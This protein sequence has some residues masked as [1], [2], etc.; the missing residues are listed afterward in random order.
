MDFGLLCGMV[1]LLSWLLCGVLP[2]ISNSNV[3]CTFSTL[4]LASVCGW[5]YVRVWGGRGG[6]AHAPCSAV[7]FF[8]AVDFQA[9]HCGFDLLRVKAHVP[10]FSFSISWWSSPFKCVCLSMWFE[11]KEKRIKTASCRGPK[12]APVSRLM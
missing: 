8:F 7:V 4:P 11:G 5:V 2:L 3:H 9:K 10:F 12:T 1:S 6:G